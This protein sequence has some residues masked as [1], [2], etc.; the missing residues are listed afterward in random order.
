M[1]KKVFICFCIFLAIVFLIPIPRYLEDGGTVEYNAVLYQVEDVH[2]LSVAEDGIGYIEGTIVR[3][4][5]FEV[6]NDVE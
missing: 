6:Y 2:R 1:K 3:I 5:G 4:L